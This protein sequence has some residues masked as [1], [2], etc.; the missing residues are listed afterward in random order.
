[1]KAICYAKMNGRL[2]NRKRLERV[3]E[4]KD[5]VAHTLG[6]WAMDGGGR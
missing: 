6:T 5:A 2:D 1:M 4:M 3:A